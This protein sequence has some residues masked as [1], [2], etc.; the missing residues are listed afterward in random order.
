MKKILL[1][2]ALMFCL[3]AS[4]FADD[5]EYCSKG[6]CI[7]S[8]GSGA[9][10]CESYCIFGFCF[11]FLYGGCFPEQAGCIDE[12]CLALDPAISMEKYPWLWNDDLPGKISKS[13]QFNQFTEVVL[14]KLQAIQRKKGLQN[15]RSIASFDA[16]YDVYF[17]T[18]VTSRGEMVYFFEFPKGTIDNSKDP[19]LDTLKLTEAIEFKESGWVVTNNHGVKT[20][21]DY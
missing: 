14:Q 19:A 9:C 3:N 17:R 5:C 21:G 7:N 1:A 10:A 16:D 11:C 15:V 12:N 18:E 13:S 20:R 2:F 8:A 4:S 6:A